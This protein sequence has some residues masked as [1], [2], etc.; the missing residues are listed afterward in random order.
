MLCSYS[1]FDSWVKG[2]HLD[3]ADTWSFNGG[4]LDVAFITP[5]IAP[6][7]SNDVIVK[8]LLGSIA[9]SSN[10]VV[11]VACVTMIGVQNTT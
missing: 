1:V 4:D 3:S 10:G 5:A 2:L 6:R 9:D 7:V 11:K 8:S